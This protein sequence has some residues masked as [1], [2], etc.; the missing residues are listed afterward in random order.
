MNDF[1]CSL[2][3]EAA[4]KVWRVNPP[5]HLREALREYLRWYM[6]ENHDWYAHAREAA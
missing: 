2:L 5:E 3:N 4:Y 6:R 1:L